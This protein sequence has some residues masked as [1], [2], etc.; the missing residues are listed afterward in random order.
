MTSLP[1]DALI[2]LPG[3]SLKAVVRAPTPEKAEALIHTL[4]KK[5]QTSKDTKTGKHLLGDSVNTAKMDKNKLVKVQLG[6][7]FR[8]RP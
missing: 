7:C 8:K 6:G 3:K 2:M 5:D 4:I 1:D